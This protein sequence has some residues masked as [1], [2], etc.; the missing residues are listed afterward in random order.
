MASFL[1]EICPDA[2]TGE[3]EA[4]LSA[5]GGDANQA[6]HALL[7]NLIR[8][9]NSLQVLAKP[10]AIKLILRVHHNPGIHVFAD[11]SSTNSQGDFIFCWI[12]I[13]VL[14]EQTKSNAP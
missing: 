14:K 8:F 7:G 13:L 3:I 11:F 1:E 2:T 9:S 6:A 5:S 12:P 4:A 10:H